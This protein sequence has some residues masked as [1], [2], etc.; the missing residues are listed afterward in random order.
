MFV[1]VCL[2]A[3]RIKWKKNNMINW[4]FS[5]TQVTGSVH[6]RMMYCVVWYRCHIPYA[7]T[8]ES[9]HINCDSIVKSDSLIMYIYKYNWI[10]NRISNSFVNSSHFYFDYRDESCFSPI[11]IPFRLNWV[12]YAAETFGC[13]YLKWNFSTNE[14]L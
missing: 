2:N 11:P 1:C 14:K 5:I 9:Y 10:R 4:V 12:T 6:C 8:M 13:I 7:N 3:I